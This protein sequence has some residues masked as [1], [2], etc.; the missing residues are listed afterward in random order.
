MEYFCNKLQMNLKNNQRLEILNLA[1]Y[2]RSNSIKNLIK[3]KV[4][5]KF[6]NLKIMI[7]FLGKGVLT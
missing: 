3:F 4:E 6:K 5:M 2:D 7:K 1:R